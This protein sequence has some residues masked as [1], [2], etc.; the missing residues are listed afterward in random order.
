MFRGSGPRV[1]LDSE[2][3]GGT[4]ARHQWPPAMLEGPSRG[5][6]HAEPTY[7]LHCSPFLWFN[8]IYN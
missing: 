4:V 1:F 6:A 5:D 8:Q 2:G 3:G 7:S